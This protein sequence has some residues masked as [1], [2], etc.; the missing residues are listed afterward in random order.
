MK[1]VNEY[2]GSL[3]PND[4]TKEIIE[5]KEEMKVHLMESIYD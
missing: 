4:K 5:L 3:Y 1:S 2:L